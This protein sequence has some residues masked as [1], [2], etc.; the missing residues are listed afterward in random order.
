YLLLAAV[1][2]LRDSQLPLLPPEMKSRPV[3]YRD[4]MAMVIVV[5]AA[6]V[7]LTFLLAMGTSAPYVVFFPAVMFAAIYGGRRAG[8]LATV[9]SA[10]LTHYFWIEPAGQ[11]ALGKPTD[12]LSLAIFL[13]SGSMIAWI[14]EAWH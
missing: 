10:I 13:L 4:A 11:F 7:R 2:A 14:A 3:L 6:A 8:L 1:A 12:W 9:L 5:A